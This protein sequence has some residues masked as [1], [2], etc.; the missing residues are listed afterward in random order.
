MTKKT[1]TEGYGRL[2]NNK[3][4]QIL[5]IKKTGGVCTSLPRNKVD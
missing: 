2:L 5:F 1:D 3:A 4:R